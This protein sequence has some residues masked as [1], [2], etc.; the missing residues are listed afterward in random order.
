MHMYLFHSLLILV[1]CQNEEDSGPSMTT[2]KEVKE[3]SLLDGKR[4]QVHRWTVCGVTVGGMTVGGV[5]VGG[6]TVGGVTVGGGQWEVDSGRCDSGWWTV[7][8]V[9]V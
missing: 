4:A 8:G 6:M 3:M 7:G 1:S 2:V 9:I 5:T